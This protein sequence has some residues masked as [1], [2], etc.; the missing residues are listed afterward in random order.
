MASSQDDLPVTTRR[1]VE[2]AVAQ[3]PMVR[4]AQEVG[5]MPL[6]PNIATSRRG[7][8]AGAFF[9]DELAAAVR[10][11]NPW[12]SPDAVRSVVERL[13]A[14]PPTIEGNRQ[15]LSWMRGERQ[16]YDDTEERQRFVRLI[17]FDAPNANVLHVTWEWS[18]KPPARRRGARA[19]MMFV[20]NGLPVALVEHKNPKQADAIERGVNQLKRY[21]ARTPE[22]MGS[23]QLFNV[24]HMLDYWYGVT[25]NLSRRFMARWKEPP[26]GRPAQ[27]GLDDSYRFAVQSFFEPTDFLRTL[28]DWILFYVE[29][30]ETRKTVLR[31]H[32]RRAA[33]RV[34]E[35]CAEP[36]KQRGLVWHTQGSGKTF[37]LLT[38]ARLLLQDR[39]RFQAPTVIVVVDRVDL[40]GQLRDWVERLLG[41]M[42]KQDIPVHKAGS[43]AELADLLRTDKR[44]LIVSMI[45]K[46]EGL[47]KDAN[48]R[49]NV[50]VFI[51]EAHRSVARDLGTYLMGAVPNATIVGFTGTPIAKTEHGQGTFKIFG[52]DDEKGYLDKYT[53]AES[54]EDETTLPIRHVMA[55]SETT[56]PAQQL[57]DEF[58]AL[59]AAEGVTD[60]DELNKVLDRAVGLRA[61]LTADDRVDKVAAYVARHFQEN[62]VPLG[63]K[64][65]LV[66]VN[67]EACAKYKQALDKLL[68]AEWTAPVYT[69]NAD[70]VVK[71]PI[72]ADLQLSRDEED[73]ARMMFKKTGENPRILIVTDKLLTG[74]DAPLLYCMYLDKPMRDHVLLQAIAR[75]NRP[76]VDPDTGA[77]KRIGLVV[78]FVGVLQA[79]EKALRFDSTDVS[80]VVE[81]IDVL[82]RDFRD[83]LARAETTYLSTAGEGEIDA[84]LEERIYE[85]LRDPAARNEFF[86]SY[87][88][89]EALMEIL[90]PSDE[91]RDHLESYQMLA[92]LYASTRAAYAPKVDYVADLAAKT[93]AMIQRSA[94]AEGLGH[95][96]RTVTFDL[97]TVEALRGGSQ[98]DAAKVFN[99]LRGMRKEIDDR[100]D[101]AAVL[102]PLLER[103]ERVRQELEKRQTSSMKAMDLL[104]ALAKEK[105]DALAAA[106][107]S[108][109]SARAFGVYWDLRNESA[110]ATVGTSAKDLA[111]LVDELLVRFPNAR[112]SVQENRLL[113]GHL[114]GPLLKLTAGHRK[115]LVDRIMDLAL[116]MSDDDD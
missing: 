76:H 50:F 3:F 18:I 2:A 106:E 17:D 31:Q 36:K 41:E 83:K 77:R 116:G 32:Q 55:P 16:W 49:D 11:F 58:F 105:D 73:D 1:L 6:E 5:W 29:D 85:Q 70:D 109:L 59:A 37:T 44:G 68:P 8:R 89:I 78:D 53:I 26:A 48:T 104:S 28:R 79:L 61:F 51:D 7:G 112:R 38:A 97:K 82:L 64:A 65:F 88:E 74:F 95:A 114:Y 86:E 57:D 92:S 91:L 45:H 90:S 103:A 98:S 12:L 84:W 110:L 13:E 87:K 33:T 56:V 99:L 34:V 43:K 22:L 81:G 24:T 4:H 21:E 111:R 75:V 107:E 46:F 39:Q 25:W 14:T 101:L 108:G 27:P 19:D 9:R 20:V 54:I 35:R 102:L 23:A 113:R 94:V 10:R 96:P 42:Q 63:Y 72:V 60:V 67:R 69:E 40:E 62:V 80:G 15:M 30:G 100:P 52:A 115:R 66:G 93:R 71:R 47:H